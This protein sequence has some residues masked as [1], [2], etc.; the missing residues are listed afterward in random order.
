MPPY[1][2]LSPHNVYH[3]SSQM[4]ES[5]PCAASRFSVACVTWLYEGG[6][7][8]TLVRITVTILFTLLFLYFSAFFIFYGIIW[9]FIIHNSSYLFIRRAE[10]R[11]L[12]L[13]SGV[14]MTAVSL[15]PRLLWSANLCKA[16]DLTGV[17]KAVGCGSAGG[18]CGISCMS[19][20]GGIMTCE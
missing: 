18:I 9:F 15:S 16:R 10:R 2:P 14:P 17:G 4:T 20:A 19:A 13:L 8:E 1:T 6:W 7:C 3:S 12:V 5:V 11:V